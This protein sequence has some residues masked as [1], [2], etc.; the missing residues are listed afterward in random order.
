MWWWTKTE[1]RHR[2]LSLDFAMFFQNLKYE[3]CGAPINPSFP[4]SKIYFHSAILFTC[5]LQLLPLFLPPLLPFSRSSS[6]PHSNTQAS[7]KCASSG[8]N[9]VYSTCTPHTRL[10]FP[11]PVCCNTLSFSLLSFTSPLSVPL[12]P[13][14]SFSLVHVSPVMQL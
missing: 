7:S 8:T 4:L 13:P 14:N 11:Q 9:I 6:P 2:S 3:A 1:E 12:T 5:S 10:S